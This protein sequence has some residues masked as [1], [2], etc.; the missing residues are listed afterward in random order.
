[1]IEKIIRSFTFFYKYSDLILLLI[2][3]ILRLPPLVF[4]G[5]QSVFFNSHSLGRYLLIFLLIIVLI[6][7]KKKPKTML[8]IL[9]LLFLV[10]KSLSI[11]KAV[12]LSGFF[13]IYKD[14]IWGIIF[15]FV[16]FNLIN[17]KVQVRRIVNV[18]IITLFINLIFQ[19]IIYFRS[20]FYIN[21]LSNFLYSKYFE[22]FLI[23]FNRGR[24]FVDMLFDVSL[25]PILVF[26]TLKGI[27]FFKRIFFIVLIFIS[28]FYSLVSGFR[29]QFIGGFLSLFLTFLFIK[30]ARKI[31]INI[32]LL[33]FI[34]LPITYS[35]NILNI[36]IR[37]LTLERFSF[38]ETQAV[39][40]IF[41]RFDFWDQGLKMGL[42]SPIIGV[43][44]GNYYDYY[45]QKPIFL[46]SLF[47]PKNKLFEVTAFH[48][49]NIFFA[50]FSETGFLGLFSLILL[51][52]YFI[53]TDYQCIKNNK[54]IFLRILIINFWSLFLFSL[55]MPDNIIQ[56][57]ILF[58]LFRVL[59]E[60][61]Q[62]LR[63]ITWKKS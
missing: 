4:L 56:Y 13:Y 15:L 19:T 5:F 8:L 11:I 43:G 21:V 38:V 58:W 16:S 32:L 14:F 59:I 6:K 50:T 61:T 17:K 22:N 45:T 10:V 57:I 42:S 60:K 39:S 37:F 54:A 52:I 29:I 1:M 44:L 20:D 25:L 51:L 12:S 34:L 41:S 53:K 47:S 7:R 46:L 24:Y 27:N 30:E 28:L 26:F 62:K 18:L 2:I 48:P 31:I 33:F 49:H 35:K 9:S 36:N 3:I 40:S 63:V 55:V 23:H